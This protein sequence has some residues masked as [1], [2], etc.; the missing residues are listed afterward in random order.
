MEN[1][2]ASRQQIDG[3]APKNAEMAL[4]VLNRPVERHS[5]R[6]MHR[7]QVFTAKAGV[8]TSSVVVKLSISDEQKTA[9]FG[10]GL[11]GFP[12]RSLSSQPR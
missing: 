5:G 3:M 12:L 8:N 9:A 1:W 4:R 2:L 7:I 10:P 11:L 6:G